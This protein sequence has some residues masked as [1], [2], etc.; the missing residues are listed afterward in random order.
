M[1]KRKQ[2]VKSRP[3][4]RPERAKVTAEEALKRM[5]DFPKRKEQFIA[6]V[7]KG[8]ERP[9]PAGGQS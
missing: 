1:A 2:R 6:S 7:R 3:A 5:A 8:K 9:L 4:E